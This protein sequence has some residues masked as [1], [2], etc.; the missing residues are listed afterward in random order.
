M[1]KYSRREKIKAVALSNAA[2]ITVITFLVFGIFLS[3]P[4]SEVEQISMFGSKPLI[5]LQKILELI[6]QPILIAQL[7]FIITEDMKANK[8]K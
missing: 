3:Y 7:V 1:S 4:I 5:W 8:K 2:L 6:I